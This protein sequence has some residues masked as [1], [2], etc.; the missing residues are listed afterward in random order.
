MIQR[1]EVMRAEINQLKL[2]PDEENPSQLFES[3]EQN[4]K[5]LSGFKKG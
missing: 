4:L 1:L 5:V 2:I 3:I